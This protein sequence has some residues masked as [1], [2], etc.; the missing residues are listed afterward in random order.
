MKSNEDPIL[1]RLE[2][3]LDAAQ[4]AC[5][6][7][8]APSPWFEQRMLQRLRAD[9]SAS[10]AALEGTLIFRMLCFAVVVALV[11]VALPLLQIKNPY[12]ETLEMVNSA[13]QIS[14]YP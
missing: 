13:A 9:T 1:R 8:P 6:P 4:S 3:L 2:R 7:V 12:R 5:P 14:Q 10:F 11:S